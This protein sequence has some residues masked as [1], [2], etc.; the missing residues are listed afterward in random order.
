MCVCLGGETESTH[1]HAFWFSYSFKMLYQ[2][3]HPS[4][5]QCVS[6]QQSQNNQPVKLDFLL[7]KSLQS[8][9]KLKETHPQCKCFALRAKEDICYLKM[10]LLPPVCTGFFPVKC[11]VVIII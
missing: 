6:S 4:L 8:S 2:P 5:F 11:A 1:M 9:V 10:W 7:M 3:Y